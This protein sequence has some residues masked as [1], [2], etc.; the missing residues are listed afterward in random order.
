MSV[1]RQDRVKARWIVNQVLREALLQEHD[2]VLREHARAELQQRR[3][4]RWRELHEALTN[5]GE[6]ARRTG[7]TINEA[8]EVLRD[9]I[10]REARQIREEAQG[11]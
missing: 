9:D 2:P 10:A 5:I 8:W 1:E 4:E 3:M 11:G 6:A 7:Q